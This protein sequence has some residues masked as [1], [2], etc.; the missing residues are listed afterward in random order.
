M[1]W[2][3]RERITAAINHVKPDRVSIDMAPLYEFYL[4]LKRHLGLELGEEVKHNT[5][6]EVTP[7]PRYLSGWEWISS[8]S[9]S[10]QPKTKRAPGWRMA[11]CRMSGVWSIAR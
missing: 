8:R 9:N 5:F 1:K 6:M 4:K 3:S 11:L 10:V 2:T 7:H